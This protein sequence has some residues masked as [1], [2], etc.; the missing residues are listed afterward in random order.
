MIE[1]IDVSKTFCPHAIKRLRTDARKS[2]ATSDKA[3]GVASDAP[4]IEKTATD[5]VLRDINLTLEQGDVYGIIG[6]SGAGK[7]TLARCVNLL[8]RPTLGQVIVDGQDITNFTGRDLLDLRAKIGIVFQ[9]FNLFQQRSVLQNVTFPLEVRRDTKSARIARGK[10]LLDLVG[11][12]DKACS[13]P[14]QLSGGQQQRVSIARALANHPK[15]LLWDEATSALDTV[16]TN[17][18]LQLLREINREL[19]VTVLVIT[20]EM[21]VIRKV[22]N[23]VAVIDEG[24][25]VERGNVSDIFLAPKESITKELLAEVIISA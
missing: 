13:Y 24:R 11:L 17:S 21:S 9:D 10:A 7:S 22:C 20:H 3:G 12:S 5:W 19:S 23:K 14:S 8:E 16:T 25:I 2:A 1:F 4:N 18:I 15:Y 6:V